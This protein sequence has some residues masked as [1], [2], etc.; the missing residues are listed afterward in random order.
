VRT[1]RSLPWSNDSAYIIRRS[2]CRTLSQRCVQP[3]KPHR[4]GG[5]CPSRA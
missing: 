1:H 2:S 3:R 5:L 4:F